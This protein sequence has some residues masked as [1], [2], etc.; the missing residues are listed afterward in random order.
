MQVSLGVIK[1]SEN[2]LDEMCSI[3][4]ELHNYVPAERVTLKLALPT[5]DAKLLDT[6][7]FHRILLGG[8]VD[9]CTYMQQL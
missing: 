3:L 5:G 2:K 1:K 4:K 8:P 6:E 7:N 9:C